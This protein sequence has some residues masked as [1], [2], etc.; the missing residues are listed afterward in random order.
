MA[1]TGSAKEHA[2]KQPLK[3]QQSLTISLPI[4][5]LVTIA[6]TTCYIY[7]YDMLFI[8]PICHQLEVVWNRV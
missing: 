6:G 7:I 5:K 8:W 3:H 4:L 2:Q 1:Y